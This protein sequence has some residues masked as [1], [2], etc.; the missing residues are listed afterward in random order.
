[1]VSKSEIGNR[2][3][4]E[5]LATIVSSVTGTVLVVSLARLLD[6]TGYGLLYL[7]ISIIG[8]VQV[9]A[10]LG[11]KGST[12][13]FIAEYKEHDTTQIPH[14]IGV[15]FKFIFFL[16]TLTA[17]AILIGQ[18]IIADFFGEPDLVSFLV[19]GALFLVFTTFFRY[20][21]VVFQGFEAIR[22]AAISR[23]IY[24]AGKLIFVLGLAFLGFGA[25][26]AMVG[27]AIGAAIGSIVSLAIVYFLFFRTYKK[28]PKMEPG[29]RRRI[30]EYSIPL[31]ATR[32]ARLAD[33]QL[34]I[35][36][37]GFFLNPAAVS[38]YVIAKQVG[39]LLKQPS[40][41]LGFTLGPTFGAQASAGNYG[42]AARI[43][44]RSII[45]I[46][47]LYIP[48]AVG[49]VLL[50]D[51]GINLIFGN[52]YAGAIP[53]LQ[54]FAF[55][56]I[57]ITINQVTSTALN[58]LGLAKIRAIA[59]IITSILNVSLNIIL[60]PRIG[61]IGAA[62]ATTFTFAI[63]VSV[64]H[65]YI[66]REFPIRWGYI[67][68]MTSIICVISAIMGVFI[69]GIKQHINDVL[70]FGI[71]VMLGIILWGILSIVTGILDIE[72][73]KQALI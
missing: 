8:L 45:N 64:N 55:Y 35:I 31:T 29:L 67:L 32:G 19:I 63:Y 11:F 66:H 3:R 69:L 47:A 2:F 10:D 26:G 33:R 13:R 25:V 7:S 12:G 49:T 43:F 27:Y 17:I 9:F 46:F 56:I 24:S 61:V 15:S 30:V 57:L 68:K 70:T 40:T 34:D 36:L 48:A 6:P 21:R 18:H 22:I 59:K 14:I 39:N 62:F 42:H 41:A 51:S 71:V 44:E 65:Y 5:L 60:I 52:Q 38:Y 1:M 20:S 4:L 58:Y 50:A 73:V 53:V 37:V 54:I 72:E 23:I 16:T 28:A